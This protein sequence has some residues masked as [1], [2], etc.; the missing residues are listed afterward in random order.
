MGRGAFARRPLREGQVV[1]PAPLQVFRDRSVFMTRHE[2]KSRDGSGDVELVT[3]EQLFVNYCF[4]PR[5]SK[6]L[7]FPYGQ[8][9]N[10]INHASNRRMKA[11]ASAGFDS[12]GDGDRPEPNVYLRWSRHE[13]H[14]GTWLD[15]PYPDEFWKVAKPGGLILEVVASRPIEIG[16]ELFMD[17]GPEWEDAWLRHVESW[18]PPTDVEDYAY[19]AEMDETAPLRTVYEQKTDPYPSNLVTTCSTPDWSSRRYQ[20]GRNI[21][22]YDPEGHPWWQTMA[23]CHILERLPG[24]TGDPVYTVQLVWKSDRLDFDYEADAKRSADVLHGSGGGGRED[25]YIDHQVPRRAIRF[26]ERPY[27]D[28]EHLPNAFRHPIALPDELTPASWRD[29]PPPAAEDER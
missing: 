6:M 20:A 25:R 1:V 14:R 4:Q 24:P 18:V 15:L 23:Y 3:E 13:M 21:T 19:P 27:A 29:L 22:W 16:E 10:L 7:L 17:Y 9:V 2:V 8:G 28:D 12:I 26:V 11:T 5:N